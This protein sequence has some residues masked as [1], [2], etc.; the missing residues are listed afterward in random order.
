[1]LDVA[2]TGS[3]A[4]FPNNGWVVH[5][6]QTAW[7]AITK[8]GQDLPQVFE[9]CVRAGNDTDTTAAIAGGLIGASLGRSG[10][11][12][13]WT[14]VLHGYPGLRVVDLDALTRAIVTDSTGQQAVT[15]ES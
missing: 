11:L 8:A 1:M 14:A 9:L 3:P 10:V 7:W 15:G 2:E 5:A 4:D 6:L 12:T 13:E